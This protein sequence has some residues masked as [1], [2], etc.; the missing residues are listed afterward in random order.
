MELTKE[1]AADRLG[2]VLA[3]KSELKKE[4]DRL[5]EFLISTGE[6][7]V[8]G[9]MFNA[10]IADKVRKS[11][12]MKAAREKLTRQWMQAHTKESH[13]T[14]VRVSARKG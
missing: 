6:K 13:F 9:S 1:Y 12:D 7:D 4:E 5:K 14:E 8:E 3:S 11:L 2:Q 10:H